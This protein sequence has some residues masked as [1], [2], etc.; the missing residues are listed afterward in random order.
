LEYLSLAAWD[1]GLYV[2][3][4]GNLYPQFY[5]GTPRLGGSAGYSP[6]LEGLLT[7]PSVSGSVGN[8]TLKYNFGRSADS[9]G[10]G[11]GTPGA[12]FTYGFGPFGLFSSNPPSFDD[13]YGKWGSSPSTSAPAPDAAAPFDHRFGSWGDAPDG[14]LGEPRSPVLRELLKYR[15]SAPPDGV[16]P[17]SDEEAAMTPRVPT[18]RGVLA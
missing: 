18:G 11:F 16:G 7:G 1:F 3:N 13:R 14:G 12:G 15:R 2:D 4:Y 6:D 5:Y 9:T 8:R 17:I 10:V